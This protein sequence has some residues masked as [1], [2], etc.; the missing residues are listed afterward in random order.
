MPRGPAMRPVS[1]VP[2]VLGI[3]LA[4]AGP[5]LATNGAAPIAFG[6]KSAGRAGAETAVAD[7]AT[8]G[9]VNPAALGDLSG[10]RL[11]LG[12]FW[13][14][15][16]QRYRD[17]LQNTLTT[18]YDTI[19]PDVG[20]S[21]DPAG[22]SDWRLGL[23]VYA[24][25]GGGGGLEDFKTSVFPDGERDVTSVVVLAF[26][27]SVAWRAL[28][29]LSF[30]ASLN[31]YLTKID[32]EGLV[33]STGQGSKGLVF[34]YRDSAGNPLP[35]PEPVVVEGQQ[36]TYNEL[37]TLTGTESGKESTRAIIK[38]A[39]GV[40]FGGT[41]GM[42]FHATEDI[43][44]GLS[45]RT[46]AKVPQVTGDAKI[47][48]SAGIDSINNDPDFAAF[49]SATFDAYL[50]DG[51]KKGFKSDYKFKYQDFRIPAVLSLGTAI[52]P[53]ERVLLALDFRWIFWKH[54]FDQSP[55]NLTGGSNNDINAIQG[56]SSANQVSKLK[57]RDQPVVA[58]GASF[59]ATEWLV[60]RAGYNWGRNPIP[61]TTTGPTTG[62]IE[63]HIALGAGF[64]V[65]PLDIDIAYIYGIPTS[66]NIDHSETN[67]AYDGSSFKAEQHFVY[68]GVGM[69]F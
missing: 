9:I 62:I 41:F 24:P 28:E 7:D 2:A 1:R 30:G 57:W 23:T 42:L 55:I 39:Y 56:G 11:D 31:I 16:R 58:V 51:G 19:A 37:F 27:P 25:L 4:L 20:F 18:T 22:G 35:A 26:A 6:P 46:E 14:I 13:F 67:S 66:A 15:S 21:V 43:A 44:F 64:Y 3:L 61:L 49:G 63:H 12:G 60:L 65:G 47:D 40:G 68:F 34:R 45:Y 5:A 33:G 10:V 69:T 38:N 54:A 29:S 32:S 36:V 17:E 52:R 53:H 50:P 48:A 8:S 59:L